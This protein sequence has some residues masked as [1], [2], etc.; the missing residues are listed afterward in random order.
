MIARFR[1]GTGAAVLSTLFLA[2]SL[3]VLGFNYGQRWLIVVATCVAALFL[4]LLMRLNGWL[5]YTFIIFCIGGA[6][7]D[8]WRRGEL[9]WAVLLAGTVAFGLFQV[10]REIRFHRQFKDAPHWPCA[11]GAFSGNHVDKGNRVLF[12]VYEVNYSHYVGSVVAGSMLKKGLKARLESLVGKPVIVRYK[13][14][15]PEIST[16]LSSDQTQPTGPG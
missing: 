10:F 11:Q 12:Y 7:R 6:S 13:P 16:L 9:L 8:S 2:F 1:Y 15:K 3:G 4:L 5:W 14:D